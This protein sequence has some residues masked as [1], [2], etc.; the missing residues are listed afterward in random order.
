MKYWLF[1]YASFNHQ[2]QCGRT[3]DLPSYLLSFSAI[4]K[5]IVELGREPVIAFDAWYGVEFDKIVSLFL[6]INEDGGYCEVVQ[7]RWKK[8]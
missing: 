8:G 1:G 7:I 2:C 6:D 5:K 4:D 3:L